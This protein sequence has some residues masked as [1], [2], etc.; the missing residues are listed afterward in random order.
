MRPERGIYVKLLLIKE[1]IIDI[2]IIMS[3]SLV[4]QSVG[5]VS[6]LEVEGSIPGTPTILKMC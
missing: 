6:D 3:V 2:I 5:L 1:Y 4:Y